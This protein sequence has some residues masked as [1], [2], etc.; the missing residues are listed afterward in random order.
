MQY[1][2][3]ELSMIVQQHSPMRIRICF[4]P[5]S[6]VKTLEIVSPIVDRLNN[7]MI[8]RHTNDLTL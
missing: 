3:D 8:S 2:N 1:T 4:L 7:Q 5:K 6:L